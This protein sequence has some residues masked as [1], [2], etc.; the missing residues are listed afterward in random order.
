MAGEG[1]DGGQVEIFLVV[2]STALL[3]ISYFFISFL[4]KIGLWIFSHPTVCLDN[5]SMFF[6]C[7]A[8][9]KTHKGVLKSGK[10]LKFQ[11]FPNF[12]PLKKVPKNMQCTLYWGLNYSPRRSQNEEDDLTILCQ[13]CKIFRAVASSSTFTNYM[14]SEVTLQKSSEDLPLDGR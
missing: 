13:E 2:L 9:N 10:I 4:N 5:K 6:F 7:N 12:G 8:F 1:E 11:T 14:L 3:K